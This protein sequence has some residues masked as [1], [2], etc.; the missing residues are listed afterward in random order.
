M[1]G[2][3]IERDS[4]VYPQG[5][6]ETDHYSSEA[7]AAYAAHI[8]GLGD[9]P[10]GRRERAPIHPHFRRLDWAIVESI[11]RLARIAGEGPG[12]GHTMLEGVES[13]D[14]FRDMVNGAIPADPNRAVRAVLVR[15]SV[16]GR[17]VLADVE[18][19]D[20]FPPREAGEIVASFAMLPGRLK[21]KLVTNFRTGE[22]VEP[23]KA[24]Q[25]N[26][27]EAWM[28]VLEIAQFVRAEELEPEIRARMG[29]PTGMVCVRRWGG[30]FNLNKT[31]PGL[32]G[33]QI[34]AARGEGPEPE[35]VSPAEVNR[36]VE[37]E[38]RA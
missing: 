29:N 37:R 30:P 11:A 23:T 31:V 18:K 21:G 24:E 2:Y 9:T 32:L 20:F 34:A 33:E 1:A 7:L 27:I 8:S 38:L 13:F 14:A 17:M 5:T 16:L 3:V 25:R 10:Q 6:P 15:P 12:E 4:F 19:P 35:L 26:P 28:P 22:F 36:Q